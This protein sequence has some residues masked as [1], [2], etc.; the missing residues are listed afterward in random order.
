MEKSGNTQYE[1]SII[2]WFNENLQNI[3]KTKFAIDKTI[4][5]IANHQF[6]ENFSKNHF[7][8]RCSSLADIVGD[9]CFSKVEYLFNKYP[10]ITLSFI[11]PGVVF[12]YIWVNMHHFHNDYQKD[13][14]DVFELFS[15]IN[16]D[17]QGEK[18]TCISKFSPS[19]DYDGLLPQIDM[20][21]LI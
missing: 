14:Q 13:F 19:K 7:F 10:K 9:F 12:T 5:K 15:N 20:S 1:Y 3:G 16:Y 17:K 6:T 11:I 21:L 8:S 4:V 2:K 18:L